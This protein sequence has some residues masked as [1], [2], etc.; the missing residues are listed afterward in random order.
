MKTDTQPGEYEPGKSA[1][2]TQ[3]LVWDIYVKNLPLIK[4]IARRY[5]TLDP[6]NGKEDFLNQAY[7]A[8]EYALKKFR[9]D[10]EVKFST[11]LTWC[12]QKHF[13]ALC[14]SGD[15]QVE[16]KDPDG[17]PSIMSYREF[18]KVKKRLPAGT[19]WRVFSRLVS[20]ESVSSGNGDGQLGNQE[21]DGEEA[22]RNA[23]DPWR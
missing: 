1:T 5:Q 9:T 14:P 2:V 19:T 20:L 4:S 6:V 17:A 13:E 10:S 8:V 3:T 22:A 23:E 18:Q 16:L 7:L 15:K 12:L 21:G 11:F